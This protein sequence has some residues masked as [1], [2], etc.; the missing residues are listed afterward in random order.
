VNAKMEDLKKKYAKLTH[1][2]AG[3]EE[4]SIVRELMDNIDF[5]FTNQVLGFPMP[6]KFKMPRVDKYDGNGDPTKQVESLFQHFSLHGTPDKVACR[7]FPFTLV[8]IAKG[9]FARLPAKSVDNFKDLRCLFLGQFL[10][11]RKRKKHPAC[12]LS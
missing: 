11:T 7:T 6:D 8:V 2:L 10:A 5:P 1:Q 12:L 4:N 3:K 9:W